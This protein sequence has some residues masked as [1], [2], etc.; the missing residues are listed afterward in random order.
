MA[1]R[2]YDLYFGTV[3][4]ILFIKVQCLFCTV[5]YIYAALLFLS[6]AIAQ[7]S[8][9][10]LC[11]VVHYSTACRSYTN[12]S[13]IMKYELPLTIVIFQNIVIYILYTVT[14]LVIDSFIHLVAETE[15]GSLNE[16]CL[17]DKY[18]TSS[19]FKPLS[20]ISHLS[21]G[22]YPLS[23]WSSS[24]FSAQQQNDDLKSSN[25]ILFFFSEFFS[26]IPHYTHT[27]WLSFL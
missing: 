27:A 14:K 12:E 6:D 4:Y 21:S 19:L 17:P 3:M 25:N 9:V 1:V 5:H 15:F 16:V 20:I 8:T 11:S 7:Y 23:S 18:S 10:V 13:K 2:N 22:F 26:K 24:L